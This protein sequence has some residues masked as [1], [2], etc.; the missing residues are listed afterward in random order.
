[1]LNTS[2][3]DDS[4]HQHLLGQMDRGAF[5]E[6]RL[7]SV[8]M[9]VANAPVNTCHPHPLLVSATTVVDS[10]ILPDNIPPHTPN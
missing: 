1:M 10:A 5:Q 2:R 9:G 6:D 3:G 8:L 7:E 4:A